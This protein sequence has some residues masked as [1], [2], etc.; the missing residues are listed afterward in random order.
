MKMLPV[1][2]LCLCG[3]VAAVDPDEAA[4]VAATV[5][6][7]ITATEQG[8]QREVQT[9]ARM[10]G[11]PDRAASTRSEAAQ[12]LLTKPQN[13]AKEMLIGFLTDQ[14]NPSA[15]IAVARAIAD[16]GATDTTFVDPLFD[17][18]ADDQE[19]V[20][21]AAAAALGAY[22][23]QAV[24][25]ALCRVARDTDTAEPTRLAAAAGLSRRM[26]KRAVETL[27]DL[28]ADPEPS[29]RAASQAA[30]AKLT[31]I[32]T[33]GAS[34]PHWLAWWR[35]NRDKPRQQWLAEQIDTLTRQSENQQ[36]RLNDLQ[37]RLD[38]ALVKLYAATAPSGQAEMVTALLRDPLPEVRLV[39]LRLASNRV[40]AGEPSTEDAATVVRSLL[41]DQSP[42]VRTNAARLAADLNDAEAAQLIVSRLSVEA[43]VATRTALIAAL[44]VLGD[45]EAVGVLMAALIDEPDTVA[46]EAALAIERL[47]GRAQLPAVQ[48]DAIVAAVIERHG[49]SHRSQPRLRR[50]LLSAM[51]AIGRSEFAP[52]MRSALADPVASIRL[53]AIRGLQSLNVAEAAA[54]IAPLAADPDR[55]VRQAAIT[56]LGAL[57][58]PGHLTAVLARTDRDTETD[59]VIRQRAWET[60]LTLLDKVDDDQLARIATELTG[61]PDALEYQIRLLEMLAA[62]LDTDKPRQAE[63]RLQLADALLAAGRPVEAADILAETYADAGDH[64]QAKLLWPAW[65]RALLAADDAACLTHM[66]DQADQSLFDDAVDLLTQRLAALAS[67]KKYASLIALADAARKHLA[68][69][70]PPGQLDLIET[71]RS[72]A[73]ERQQEADRAR[74]A[75]LISTLTSAEADLRSEAEASLLTMKTRAVAPLVERLRIDLAAD[76][77]D[78]QLQQ[79]IVGLLGALAPELTGFDESADAA[80]KAKV[81][82]AWLA[83][84]GS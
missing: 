19:P 83:Q 27:I 39:G 84:L 1:I 78:I 57:G 59:P 72:E 48:T 40:A 76:A 55:G 67:A 58:D 47:A 32:H 12:L 65:M 43:E 74:A 73:T 3:C 80:S 14:M 28:L 71:L 29:L 50:A 37:T 18:L 22:D 75:K 10:L 46:V 56:T 21:S 6:E 63:A 82:G 68:D 36:R 69:R 81:V 70:L 60:A 7:S 25:A 26:D 52:V 2:L 9:L 61:R 53:E 66:A 17:M 15:R 54:D 41:S 5:D 20:R 11:D 49:N 34:R 45:G 77:P 42:D 33:F 31:G 16:I 8:Q 13:Q 51:R 62:R 38:A 24:L 64:P 79:R 35:A 44:G 30:L 23:D 4:P